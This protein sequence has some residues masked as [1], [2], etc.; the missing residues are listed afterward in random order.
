MLVERSTMVQF[1]LHSVD[2]VVA[3]P[4]TSPL[5]LVDHSIPTHIV[6]QRRCSSI[7]TLHDFKNWMKKFFKNN[8]TVWILLVFRCPDKWPFI[9][10]ILWFPRTNIKSAQK[11]CFG[12]HQYTP[13]V[14]P[15]SKG[16]C[17]ISQQQTH[18]LYL[19]EICLGVN[20]EMCYAT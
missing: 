3:T 18:Y 10:L 6:P 9:V 4:P 11:S 19:Q 5:K 1:T 8:A 13:H 16:R 12:Y 20:C 17:D 7:I 2:C 14:S 15:V